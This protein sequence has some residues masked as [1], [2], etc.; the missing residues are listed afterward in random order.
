MRWRCVGLLCVGWGVG[1]AEGKGMGRRRSREEA[2]AAGGWGGAGHCDRNFGSAPALKSNLT[3]AWH[4]RTPSTRLGW[5][6]LR[7]HLPVRACGRACV[8]ACMRACVRACP[9]PLQ[10]RATSPRTDLAARRQRMEAVKACGEGLSVNA[11]VG[12]L[13]AAPDRRVSHVLHA[14]LVACYATL[15]LIRALSRPYRTR[16]LSMPF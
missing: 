6:V 11:S 13:C 7:H 14:S 1:R 5:A 10:V 16:T 15:W 9:P 2:C 4:D 12:R 8:R 3:M